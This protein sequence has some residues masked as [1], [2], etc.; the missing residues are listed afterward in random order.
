MFF[1]LYDI[2]LFLS[3]FAAFQDFF[4][5]LCSVLFILSAALSDMLLNLYT[6]FFISLTVFLSS[7]SSI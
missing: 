6:S 7:R 5:A 1:T 3:V 4:N 2:P